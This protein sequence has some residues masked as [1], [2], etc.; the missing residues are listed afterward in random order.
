MPFPPQ[1]SLPEPLTALAYLAGVTS[2]IRLATGVIVLPQRNP[3]YAAKQAATLDWLSGGR[4]DLT[5]GIGWSG[6][7]FERY[8][9]TLGQAWCSLRRVRLPASSTLGGRADQSL[10]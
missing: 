2:R 6:L 1:T 4:L 3:V 5:V 8:R 7:Q 9:H 10:G